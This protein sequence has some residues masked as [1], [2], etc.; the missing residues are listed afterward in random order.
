MR[1]MAPAVLLAIACSRTR[2]GG[3]KA[4]AD[5]AN[6][7][8]AREFAPPAEAAAAAAAGPAAASSAGSSPSA[9]STPASAL[10]PAAPPEAGEGK[11]A[12]VA[13]LD[14]DTWLRTHLGALRDAFP[15]ARGPFVVQRVELPGDRTAVLVEH[16]DEV[17]PVV[18]VVD[19]DEVVWSKRRPTGGILAPVR[20]ATIAPRPDG[21]VALFVYVASLH[22]LAARMWA[23]DGNAFAEIELGA[24]NACDALS[25]AYAPRRGWFAACTSDAGTHGQR[26]REDGTT[27]W[28]RD[29]AALTATS[30]AGPATIAMDTGSSLMLLE[31]ARA[32]GGEHLLALRFDDDA[33]PLW[34]GAVDLGVL[35]RSA[36]RSERMR[37]DALREGVVAV[38]FGPKHLEI[39]SAGTVR[40]RRAR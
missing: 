11:R 40:P 13:T 25:V 14:G 35:G 32:V 16:A 15:D 30:A 22:M 17:D 36:G 3:S 38:D 19:R 24:F 4:S 29:G 18:F 37:T 5:A 21:G 33:R 28:G 2:A 27:A 12:T 34:P 9:P 39:D 8:S 23:D 20:H 7:A 26:L 1:R 31:R 10:A 6:D